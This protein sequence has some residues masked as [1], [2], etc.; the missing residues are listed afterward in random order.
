[1][2]SSVLEKK[3]REMDGERF[4]SAPCPNKC[5]CFRMKWHYFGHLSLKAYPATEPASAFQAR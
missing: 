4:D 3:V 5:P 2:G 1:M